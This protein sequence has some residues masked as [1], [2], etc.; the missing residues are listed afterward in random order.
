MTELRQNHDYCKKSQNSPSETTECINEVPHTRDFF[1]LGHKCEDD[2][3]GIL[4]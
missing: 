3:I 4:D 1:I 2:A